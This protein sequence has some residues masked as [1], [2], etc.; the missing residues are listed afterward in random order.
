MQ[1]GGMQLLSRESE[2]RDMLGACV[3][4]FDNAPFATTSAL[5]WGES[6]LAHE[7]DFDVE[8]IIG[9]LKYATWRNALS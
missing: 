2:N 8:N 7:Y 9:S 5:V 6:E 4:L 3:V 1:H